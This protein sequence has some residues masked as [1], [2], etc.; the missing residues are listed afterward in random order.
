MFSPEAVAEFD[1]LDFAD[2]STLVARAERSLVESIS[3]RELSPVSKLPNKALAIAHTAMRR[4]LEITRAFAAAFNERLY[5]PLFVLSRAAVETGCLVFDVYAKTAS[6]LDAHDK[7]A[8]VD[9]DERV[10][11]VLLGSK[12]TAAA[13]DPEQYQALNVLT[14]IDRL[15]KTTHEGLR[16]MYDA[17]SEYAHPNY[18]GLLES[19]TEPH[20]DSGST[21]FLRDPLT[22]NALLLEVP[23]SLVAAGLSMSIIAVEQLR[24]RCEELAALCEEA[25]HDE[26]DWPEGLAYPI[27]R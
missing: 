18:A 7:A 22:A 24:A 17:L 6:M 11:R 21:E 5:I 19:Y 13:G 15:D 14:V 3:G 12:S 10:M 27:E 16:E 8:L 23:F 9:Y 25:L 26:G 2:I 4:N 1:Q 20:P